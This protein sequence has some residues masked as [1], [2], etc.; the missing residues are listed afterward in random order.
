MET[1]LTVA[2]AIVTVGISGALLSTLVSVAE[3]RRRRK[4][5]CEAFQCSP[6]SPVATAV[7]ARKLELQ[8]MAVEN[9]EAAVSYTKKQMKDDTS[10]C[11][12]Q[13]AANQ[14]WKEVSEGVVRFEKARESREQE[15]KQ[16]K[17]ELKLLQAEMKRL[18]ALGDTFDLL[19]DNSKRK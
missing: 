18:S 19:P 13:V 11:R 7:V 15:L 5:F 14:T 12:N 8:R 17:I 6:Q 9:S 4:E 1:L 16:Q 2:V 10:Q 3:R